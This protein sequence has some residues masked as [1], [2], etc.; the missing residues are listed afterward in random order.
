MKAEAQRAAAAELQ[1]REDDHADITA[2]MAE[3][4]AE[5]EEDRAARRENAR[6]SSNVD[7]ILTAQESQFVNN[8]VQ[9]RKATRDHNAEC[10]RA[11]RAARRQSSMFRRVEHARHQALTAEE[12][13]KEEELRVEELAL[14]ADVRQDVEA[15]RA[16]RRRAARESLAFRTA[17]SH[18]VQEE[19]A[20]DAMLTELAALEQRMRE[21]SEREDV[22]D[23]KAAMRAAR[24]QSMAMRAIRSASSFG[25]G[26]GVEVEDI[27]TGAAATDAADSAAAAAA[28]VEATAEPLDEIAEDDEDAEDAEDSEEV[29]H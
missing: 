2:Y 4:R 7:A 5:I 10:R 25:L 20:E 22:A 17:E 29:E 11:A 21:A 15:Y 19:A 18:R 14:Q 24:R 28:T 26:L 1:A 16:A 8:E 3:L 23:Y 6:T 9:A 12:K 13:A 27:E